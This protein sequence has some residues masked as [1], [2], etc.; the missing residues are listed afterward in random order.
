[1]VKRVVPAVMCSSAVATASCSAM[2]DRRESLLPSHRT[3]LRNTAA[4]K[5]HIR[6]SFAG[7]AENSDLGDCTLPVLLVP[8]QQT[9]AE[10]YVDDT[11]IYWY[12]TMNEREALPAT[13]ARQTRQVEDFAS[14]G[15]R[16]CYK[17]P[18]GCG[19]PTFTLRKTLSPT[20][21]RCSADAQAVADYN[22]RS[23]HIQRL[24][25]HTCPVIRF[26][27]NIYTAFPQHTG[28]PITQHLRTAHQAA[29]QATTQPAQ[30]AQH[31]KCQQDR[32]QR[33][34]I[35]HVLTDMNSS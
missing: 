18:E 20:L 29:R 32:H 33:V 11:S 9:P 22:R 27:W 19:G 30:P 17:L 21:S 10:C 3:D 28:T 31:V 4:M 6:G 2:Q 14:S 5:K 7:R 26:M 12:V 23:K 16:C 25:L 15:G 13:A 24:L 34:P 1:M 35:T 8:A